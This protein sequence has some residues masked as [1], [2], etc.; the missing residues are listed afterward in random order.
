[1][2]ILINQFPQ[3]TDPATYTTLSQLVDV[4]PKKLPNNSKLNVWVG[5]KLGRYGATS[6]NVVFCSDQA[7]EPT[8]AEMDYWNSLV[9]PLGISATLSIHWRKE[10][11]ATVRLYDDGK[12]ILK[13]D[14]TYSKAPSPPPQKE[15]IT[16]A[17]L[18]SKLP[19]TIP[20]PQ[21]IYITGSLVKSGKSNN[22]VDL[23]VGVLTGP[24]TFEPI[25]HKIYSDIK[26]YFRELL[27][28]KVD[29][30][31]R[32]MGEREPVYYVKAYDG[33]VKCLP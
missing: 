17:W 18:R 6:G 7:T 16:A 3:N 31:H 23:L 22:D 12:L 14:L 21:P 26:E 8:N 13:N 24:D 9:T 33:G 5:G 4:L 1:M 2:G 11:V 10:D 32:I 20:F 19:D 30:G 27:G 28:A 25:D 15:I 29:V